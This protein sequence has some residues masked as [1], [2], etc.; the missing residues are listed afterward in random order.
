[1]G[2]LE[3]LLVCTLSYPKVEYDLSIVNAALMQLKEPTFSKDIEREVKLAFEELQVT[4]EEKFDDVKPVIEQELDPSSYT[5]NDYSLGIEYGGE[6]FQGH[7]ETKEAKADGN[8]AS[9]TAEHQ[10]TEDA[11]AIADAARESQN[12]N[13]TN[14]SKYI[15]ESTKAAAT[16][17]KIISAGRWYL[18][19]EGKIHFN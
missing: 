19:Y 18:M 15:D 16:E 17:Q 7:Y 6:K 1:M 9:Y 11:Q 3:T 4:G 8:G 10:T 12:T 2:E 13:R 14:I 5:N